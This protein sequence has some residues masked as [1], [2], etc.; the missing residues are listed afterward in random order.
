MRLWNYAAASPAVNGGATGRSPVNGA[1]RVLARLTGL[2][3]VGPCFSTGRPWRQCLVAY[4]PDS[5]I[6][7]SSTSPGAGRETRTWIER[8]VGRKKRRMRAH[9]PSQVSQRQPSRSPSMIVP[10][11]SVDTLTMAELLDQLGGIPPERVLLGRRPGCHRPGRN[12]PSGSLRQALRTG[13]RGSGGEARG[14]VR[15]T[16]GRG[17]DLFL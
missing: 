6:H 3:P 11:T 17:A 4:R 14:S 16:H 2:R 10:A 13:R 15:I 12:S 9:S 5:I 7:P 8:K 1:A